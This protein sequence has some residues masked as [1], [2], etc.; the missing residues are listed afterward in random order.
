MFQR[1]QPTLG[2]ADE[3]HLS[4]RAVDP[5][6]RGSCFLCSNTAQTH[7]V[8]L[9]DNKRNHD[10]QGPSFG[11]HG[12]RHQGVVRWCVDRQRPQGD[13]GACRH[14]QFSSCD[15]DIDLEWVEALNSVM[16]DN[17]LLTMPNGER[18]QFGTNV[19]SSSG[20]LRFASPATINRLSVIFLS[21]ENVDVK[22]MIASWIAQQPPECQGSLAM[23]FDSLFHVKGINPA[24]HI[25]EHLRYT[26][27]ATAMR[28]PSRITTSCLSTLR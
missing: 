28:T 5:C 7:L 15:S 26:I 12:P 24:P 23:W 4:E 19:N 16:D 14:A 22:P 25:H 21:E 8:S 3:C 1:V 10:G 27:M 9:Q 2:R 18:I 17:R 11:A 6:C 13:Q 20:N